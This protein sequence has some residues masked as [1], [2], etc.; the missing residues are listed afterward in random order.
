M[1]L[2]R[3]VYVPAGKTLKPIELFLM[4]LKDALDQRCG[5]RMLSDTLC[6]Q[7]ILLHQSLTVNDEAGPNVVQFLIV[8]IG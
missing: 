7:C 2:A 1:L 4:W 5:Q 3:R 8:K 6:R